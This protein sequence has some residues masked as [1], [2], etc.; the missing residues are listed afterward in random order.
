MSELGN[1]ELATEQYDK[2]ISIDPL[3]VNAHYNK[4]LSLRT[5]GYYHEAIKYYDRVLEIDPN[6]LNALYNK[7]FALVDL[8]NYPE[9]IRYYKT[10]I[11]MDPN[12][13]ETLKEL[14]DTLLKMENYIESMIYYD[15]AL[16][17]V[18][19]YLDA[20]VNKGIALHYLKRYDE[21]LYYYDRAL[22][23]GPNDIAAYNNK[24]TTL[25]SLKKH[26]EAKEY[27]T[28][29]LKRD[30]DDPD[31]LNN[32]LKTIAKIEGTQY[33]QPSISL[34]L[35][36]HEILPL[37]K[38]NVSIND[39][40]LPPE[41]INGRPV[42]LYI[43]ALPLEGPTPIAY[44][45]FK[46]IDLINDQTLRHVTYAINIKKQE[47]GENHDNMQS[48]SFLADVFHSHDGLLT[49]RIQENDGPFQIN[50]IKDENLGA[51][52]SSQDV[53]ELLGPLSNATQTYVFNISILGVTDDTN[54][55]PPASIPV[56]EASINMT[57]PNS[58]IQLIDERSA[59][60][61]RPTSGNLT[62][63]TQ[64]P[65]AS[66][67]SNVSLLENATQQTYPTATKNECQL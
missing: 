5:L 21:A 33:L 61:L 50:G 30:P 49:L 24:G 45:Y 18:P 3:N 52:T 7:G 56:Y 43:K 17:I 66:Q 54:A 11:T 64:A 62:G 32:K 26:F 39:A 48:K 37:T 34:Y 15:R 59:E 23:L 57:W 27:F 13:L 63:L 2:A 46:L 25:M 1:D 60:Q 8:K 47:T 67:P 9:A 12:D 55:F 41:K 19:N 22:Q 36:G 65:N 53:F 40:L 14:G 38:Q 28:E 10:V 4:G 51:W 29:V 31:G 35:E 58:N 42:T 16:E 44:L 6:N 20:L